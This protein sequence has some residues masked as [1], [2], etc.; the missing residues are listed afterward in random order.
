MAVFLRRERAAQ[1]DRTTTHFV[2]GGLPAERMLASFI[3]AQK[4]VRAL[5]V[6]PDTA[7]ADQVTRGVQAGTVRPS[8]QLRRAAMLSARSTDMG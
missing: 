5:C 2:T 8:A 4:G 6:L 7:A 3:L 1:L